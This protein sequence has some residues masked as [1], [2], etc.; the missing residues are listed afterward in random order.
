MKIA[1]SDEFQGRTQ[2]AAFLRWLTIFLAL[3]LLP[4]LA[5]AAPPLSLETDV[6]RQ[7][8]TVRIDPAQVTVG[9]GETFD[10][11]VMIDEASDLG[12]FE[13]ILHFATATVTV[14]SVTMGDFPSSTGREI[15]PAVNIIDNQAGTASLGVVTVG[16]VPGAGGTGEL[17]IV[18]LTAQGSGESVLNL[19]NVTVLDTN[20]QRQATTV[21][22]GVVRVGFAVYL[23]L[24]LKDG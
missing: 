12:G 8:P 10:V 7:D 20:A 14:D 23:P 16:S 15:I 9:A 22:D 21:E 18:T 2:R 4:T 5:L 6:A 11:S 13:F 19:Q 3:A 24:I 17:A 1:K